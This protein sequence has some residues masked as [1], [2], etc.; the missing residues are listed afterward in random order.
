MDLRQHRYAFTLVTAGMT[1]ALSGC[2]TF[3]GAPRGTESLLQVLVPQ[4]SP[5]EA[6]EMATDPYS[7]ENR[8]KGITLLSSADFG[9]QPIYLELYTTGLDDEDPS[10]RGASVRAIGRHG[11]PEHAPYIIDSLQDSDDFVRLEAS[12]ALQRIHS[13][14]AIEPLLALI[15]EENES[16]MDIRAAAADALGQYR[17]TRVVLGLIGALRD[18]RLAVNNRVQ[19]ALMIL[20]GQ[21]FGLDRVEWLRWYNDTDDIFAAAQPYTYPVF[22]RKK[23]IIEYLPLVP[24]PPNE[25]TGSPVGM[26]PVLD[27]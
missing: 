5:A 8:Y 2:G 18:S 20:T 4:T 14:E 23:K 21:N 17:E 7:A 1:L 10:V 22:N 13:Y 24:P 19:H 3:D 9:G 6:A 12:R 27:S 11:D 25:S 15:E 26:D 16:N